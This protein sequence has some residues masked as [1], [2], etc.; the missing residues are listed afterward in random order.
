MVLVFWVWINS[1][2]MIYVGVFG[3]LVGVLVGSIPFVHL[4][5]LFVVFGFVRWYAES[6]TCGIITKWWH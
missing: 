3:G 5:V 4:A 2:V 6:C 1:S